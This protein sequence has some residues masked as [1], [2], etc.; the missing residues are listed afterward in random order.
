[1]AQGP[2]SRLY[3]QLSEGSISR[4]QFIERAAAA[5][6]GAAGALFLA[7]ANV[8]AA[9][10]GSKNGFA[11]YAGQDGTPSASPGG[12]T[13][14]SVG[15]EGQTRG[16]GGE[17]RIIQ[18]QAATMANAHVS[19][20]TKD[21]LIA[22][23]VQEP[24]MNYLPDG[25]II[26]NLVSEVPSVENGMLAE[27]L[28]SVTFRLQ[29]GILWSDGEPLTSRDIQFTWEWIVNVENN[30]VN[31]TTWQAISGIETP[32]ELTAVVTFVNP[33]AI[34]FDPFVGTAKGNLLPAHSFNDEPIAANNPDFLLFPIGTGPF[35]VT[36]F[37][38]NDRVALTMNENYREANK[39]YFASINV[40]GGGDA[41]SAA[42]SVLQT[43]DYDY[44]WNLQVEPA[45]LLDLA[46]VEA[47][48]EANPERPGML[49]SEL[50]T[51]VERIHINFSD[52]NQEVNGQR[53]E[54]NTPHPF[55]ADPAVRQALNKAVPRQVIT[56]EFYGLAARTTPNILTGLEFFESPNTSWEFDVE[57]AAQILE[58]AGWTMDGDVR[59]KDGVQL[60]VNY[61]TSI[62]AV[63]Q[64]TQAVVK[65]AWQAIGVQVNLD[66]VDAGIFFDSGEG[67]DR[68]ISHNYWDIS[69]YTNN[70]DS[71]IPA[72]FFLSW[73]AGPDNNNV[74]QQSNAWQGQNY[75]RYVNP[76]FDALYD[77]LLVQTD[78]E[79]AASRLIGLNDILINDVAIIPEVNRP[80]DTYAISQTLV[81]DNI[82]LGVGF[83]LSYWNVANWRR[84]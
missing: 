41:P 63:R 73:Y 77:E 20:G 21:F 24:L 5:G 3:A 15:T 42:R 33:S 4:R 38:P 60:V 45:I 61:G 69:M 57:E 76:E 22:S 29:E 74:A 67:N 37:V 68:N 32:D 8:V 84:V 25:T 72:S 53:S 7:N 13:R 31:Q 75:Q 70:P 83:E 79:E 58:D 65:Q 46:G 1:M 55:M 80:S 12:G 64:K 16:E 52:P 18:W 78:L 54:I 81:P 17:L 47:L 35:V 10:G 59:A 39:P 14:P 28:S 56:D 9:A 30:S 27:D 44:A 36:E 43:G 40:K 19:V 11:V 62:N 51:S 23:M 49:V 6:I 26:P 48:G 34:W 2:L 82:A 66:Q 71:P 50:G